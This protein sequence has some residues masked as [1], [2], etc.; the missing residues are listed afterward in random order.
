LPKDTKMFLNSSQ[1]IESKIL[2][3]ALEADMD[4]RNFKISEARGGL[5]DSEIDDSIRLFRKGE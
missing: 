1:M 3:S 2:S 5:T 4:Y